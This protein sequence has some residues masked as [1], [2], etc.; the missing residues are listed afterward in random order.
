MSSSCKAGSSKQ[1]VV[2]DDGDIA[3]SPVACQDFIPQWE[4]A[5]PG[6][7]R[8][9]EAKAGYLQLKGEPKGTV[10]KESTYNPTK[11]YVTNLRRNVK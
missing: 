3:K 10:L 4:N 6:N 2:L 7:L 5:E 11:S 1:G 9:L 8:L